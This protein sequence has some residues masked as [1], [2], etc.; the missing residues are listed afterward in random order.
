MKKNMSAEQLKELEEYKK[1]ISSI[2]AKYPNGRFYFVSSF[3]DENDDSVETRVCDGFNSLELLGLVTRLQL[4]I[5]Y[6]IGGN[7]PPSIVNKYF[8][9]K[10]GK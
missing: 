5:T 8:V 4:S 7:D 9:E 1:D 6:Q 3:K 10:E 2:L